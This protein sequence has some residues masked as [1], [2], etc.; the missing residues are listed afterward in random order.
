MGVRPLNIFFQILLNES[1]IPEIHFKASS[2][3][4]RTVEHFKKKKQL[5]KLPFLQTG[6][7]FLVD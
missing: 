3:S 6:V 5:L 1:V 4:T 7:D 2:L